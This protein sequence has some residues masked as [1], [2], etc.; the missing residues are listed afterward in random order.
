MRQS[1][2]LVRKKEESPFAERLNKL[3][4]ARQRPLAAHSPQGRTLFQ[5]RSPAECRNFYDNR[6]ERP[7]EQQQIEGVPLD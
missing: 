1:S 3:S 7:Q 5:R 2:E 4:K 6:N